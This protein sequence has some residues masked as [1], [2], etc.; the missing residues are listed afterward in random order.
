MLRYEFALKYIGGVHSKGIHTAIRICVNWLNA[1]IMAESKWLVIK[2]EY[3]MF[4]KNQAYSSK[5][6]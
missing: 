1:N 3:L 2:Y 4:I 5:L 6:A